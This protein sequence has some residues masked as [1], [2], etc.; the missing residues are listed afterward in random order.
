MPDLLL[1]LSVADNQ[2]PLLKQFYENIESLDIDFDAD[3]EIQER[4]FQTNQ[5][6]PRD[7]VIFCHATIERYITTILP[8]I[9]PL[10][11]WFTTY[12]FQKRGSLHSHSLL[13]LNSEQVPTVR[14]TNFAD[15]EERSRLEEY[16]SSIITAKMPMQNEFGNRISLSASLQENA[17]DEDRLS[18]HPSS[19]PPDM[20]ETRLL[21][22]ETMLLDMQNLVKDLQ[23]HQCRSDYCL[24]SKTKKTSNGNFYKYFII[25]NYI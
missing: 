7:H 25:L 22:D 5:R 15:S 2:W 11:D 16:L 3:E 8:E 24:R 10:E 4:L 14:T 21:S 6:N 1:T 13:W 12:E 23:I 17:S 9:L 20:V 19:L 18:P